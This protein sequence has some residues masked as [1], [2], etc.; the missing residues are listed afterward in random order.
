M[1]KICLLFTVFLSFSLQAQ[2]K[3]VPAPDA[4]GKWSYQFYTEP[5][6]GGYRSQ[7]NYALSSEQIKV[8]RTKMDEVAE[9]LHKNPVLLAPLGFEPTVQGSIWSDVWAIRYKTELL[10]KSRVLGEV[11]LRFC[12]L[13]RNAQGSTR[14]NCIEVE[15]ADVMINS[16]RHTTTNWENFSGL[17][18][19]EKLILSD[20]PQVAFIRPAI[21]KKWENG[22][23]AYENNLIIISRKPDY[24]IH[25]T[26]GQMFDLQIRYWTDFEKKEGNSL[27]LDMILKDRDRFTRE[28][29]ALP[30]YASF[31][32]AGK[33]TVIPNQQPWLRFNPAYFD[34][35]LTRTA[36][37]LIAIRTLTNAFYQENPSTGVDYTAHFNFVRGLDPGL[38]LSLLD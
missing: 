6:K 20:E 35:A 34:P 37:Q 7:Q 26:A 16:A 10:S 5:E 27:I 9:A 1:K 31:E 4:P 3:F 14:K 22:V 11:V 8:F 24:W 23:T 2:D 29:L 17:E 38:W 15:H 18:L 32:S 12:P 30:A 28:E 21:V 25:V 33:V 36:V 19:S 13:F